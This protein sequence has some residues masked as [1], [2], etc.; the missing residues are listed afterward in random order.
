[1]AVRLGRRSARPD[2]WPGFVDALSTLLLVIIFLLCV[3][4]LAQFYLSQ[5]MTGR[6]TVLSRLNKQVV[7][8]TELLA[9]ERT[10]KRSLEDQIA[11]LTSSLTAAESERDRLKGQIAGGAVEVQAA[12]GEAGTLNAQLA[13]ERRVSQRALAQV[14]LLNQ[15]LSALR[16]QIAALEDAL[17]ASENRDRESQTKIADLGRRLNVALAQRVQ[18]LARYRSDFFGRLREILSQRSDIRVVGDRFVFQSEVLFESGQ[19]TINAEGQQELA[20]LAQAVLELSREI[21]QEINWII[22]VDGHTDQRP[23]VT[24]QFRSNW[25]LSAARAVAVVRFLISKGVPPNRLGATGFGEFQPL[26][27]GDSDEARRRNRRIEF[28][29]TER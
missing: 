23:I 14:E 21:P 12:R 17:Q 8:L 25:E 27:Q 19:A 4:M 3:F 5:E 18:E 10:G 22:R 6:E 24:A 15:Q 28:K 16:R 11:T 1:M 29:L 2:Y 13:E 9:L 26:E 7:E 20:K